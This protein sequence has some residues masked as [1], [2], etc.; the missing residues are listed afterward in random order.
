MILDN[1][2][3]NFVIILW[4]CFN[5]CNGL[6]DNISITLDYS[7]EVLEEPEMQQNSREGRT[8]LDQGDDDMEMETLEHVRIG[9][10]QRQEACISEGLR[11]AVEE[12]NM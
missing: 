10:Q 1:G 5:D 6:A 12:R 9:E 2:I 3:Q 11:N 4:F 7:Y 8:Y